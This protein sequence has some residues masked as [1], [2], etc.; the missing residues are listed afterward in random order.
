MDF[1]RY[2]FSGFIIGPVIANTIVAAANGNLVTHETRIELWV[3]FV[4]GLAFAM[5]FYAADKLI[6]HR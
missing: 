1:F 2:L 3:F 4:I 5:A 6:L